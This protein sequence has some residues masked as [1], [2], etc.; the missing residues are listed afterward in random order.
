MEAGLVVGRHNAAIADT[1]ELRDA[2]MATNFETILAANG[3]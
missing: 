2:A 3:L 1:L